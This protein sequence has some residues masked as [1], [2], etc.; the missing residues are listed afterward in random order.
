[1]RK[2]Y[3]SA[4]LFGA[5][6]F[7][8]AGT[9][10][11]CKD[12]DDD[13]NNLQEQI[14]AVASDLNDLK[15]KVEAMGGVKDVTFADGVL[16]VVSDKG[17]TTYNIPDKV[18]VTKVELING[19]LYVDGVEAGK[20]Q[21]V[22][23]KGGVLY[24]DG[25]PQKLAVNFES[26]VV[27]VIDKAAGIYT[28]TVNNETIQLPIA[29]ADV[30]FKTVYGGYFTEIGATENSNSSYGIHW[31]RST[32]EVKW[33][34]PKGD[35]AKDQ[36]VIGQTTTAK[37]SVRPIN[38]DLKANE[39]KLSL[40]SSTGE[41]AKAKVV[42]YE[43]QDNGP[44][45]T[46]SRA[47][48]STEALKQGDYILG[49]ELNSNLTDREVIESFAT[50]D[51]NANLKYALA[52]DGVIV[53]DY[54]FAIDTQLKADTQTS[55][56]AP[57]A[58]KLLI[59]GH[60]NNDVPVGTHLMAYNDGRIYDMKVAFDPSSESDAA[61]YGVK[62]NGDGTITA[63]ADAENR[64]FKFLVTLIDVNGNISKTEVVNVTFKEA[65]TATVTE[66]AP[67]AYT[68]TPLK[69]KSVVIN[70]GDVFTS[71]SD[72]DAIVLGDEADNIKWAIE[73]NDNTFVVSCA[74]S[75]PGSYDPTINATI[76]YYADA[77]CTQQIEL[78]DKTTGE[79]VKS[80]KYAKIEVASYNTAATVG[81][82]LLSITLKKKV[83]SST[84][85]LV[86]KTIKKVNVPVDV[87]L[88]AWEDLFSKS[89][90]VWDNDTYVTRITNVDGSNTSD[91]KAQVSLDAYTAVVGKGA[92]A[93]DIKVS[94]LG[95]N[96]G[97][98]DFNIIDGTV[99]GDENKAL[100]FANAKEVSSIIS[101][102]NNASI[103]DKDGNLPAENVT[104]TFMYRIGEVEAFTMV[105]ENVNVRIKS[106]FDGITYVWYDKDGVETTGP[107]VFNAVDNTIKGTGSA[108]SDKKNGLAI[109]FEGQNIE[110]GDL[111]NTAH[112]K[113]TFPNF[114]GA[115]TQT[116]TK[117]AAAKA[118][119]NLAFSWTATSDGVSEIIITPKAHS[120]K[121]L[122]KNYENSTLTLKPVN[123]II[124]DNGGTITVTFTD[125]LGVKKVVEIPF[126][127]KNL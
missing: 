122:D 95:A 3:L 66:L 126:V 105:K 35:I 124:S 53:T 42:V 94:Y 109:R 18:G 11:S 119:N 20:A 121:V 2:K 87:Q 110:I 75:I 71:L 60:A 40:V 45:H 8:S 30:E 13:I 19:T 100:D 41:V 16:T 61:V 14:N 76:K 112:G 68:V 12:Y 54:V 97:G 28:L 58:S 92:D 46:D 101:L 22:E 111:G 33:D 81:E 108:D 1:M 15:T 120:G 104:A 10:T 23:V 93:D 27:A 117:A 82:H 77:A 113:F 51:G 73:N 88:P 17:N 107:A 72:A 5:L 29:F 64:T 43:S 78:N 70:L 34:G 56:E 80:I 48:Y 50:A 49:V 57:V 24:I 85:Q 103:A 26:N 39:S 79:K 99:S 6:L 55:C 118:K 127:K 37:V 63:S 21:K 38:Y 84:S 96:I 125:I 91:Y 65:E 59:G 86:D 89:T 83:G 36:L 7:A 44:L 9:F 116:T 98:D 62:I 52:L 90:S 114:L 32:K 102:D 74:N 47:T 123:G 115:N 31:A 69:D 67:T 25:E 106:I 4:L